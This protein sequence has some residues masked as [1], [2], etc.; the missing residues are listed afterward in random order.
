LKQS[1]LIQDYDYVDNYLTERVIVFR[2][3]GRYSA[4]IHLHTLGSDVQLDIDENIITRLSAGTPCDL[5]PQ[6]TIP[7]R[8]PV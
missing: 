8:S 3:R 6:E 2:G 4:V 5:E 7:K 1:V